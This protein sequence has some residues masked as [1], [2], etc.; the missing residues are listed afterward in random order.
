MSETLNDFKA[1]IRRYLREL[2]PETS[3]WTDTFIIELFN[4]AYRR[5]CAQMIMAYEGWFTNVATRDIENGKSTYGFPSGLQKVLKAELV[6]SDGKTVP[7]HAYNRH[8]ESNPEEASGAGDQ[9]YP[10]YRLIG[11]GLKLEPEPIED[12]TDGL[13]IEYSGL[14]PYLEADGDSISSSFPE[15]FDELL[16]LDTVVAAM[17][18]EG[19]HEAGP[20]P[21]IYRMRADF[22]W[23]FARFIETRAIR[24]EA[25][26]PFICHYRDY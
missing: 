8:F 24:R 10:T 14:P 18:A 21:A 20:A 11:N 13:R 2:N 1:R 25:V 19:V 12:V 16:V 22:E 5:R 6:R 9:Y 7:I 23:D 3:F 26:V 4:A 17:E 15:I